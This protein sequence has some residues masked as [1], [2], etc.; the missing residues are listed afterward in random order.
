M[1]FS[2]AKDIS[3]S[4]AKAFCDSDSAVGEVLFLHK[5][6]PSRDVVYFG[7][8]SKDLWSIDSEDMWQEQVESMSLLE[9][10]DSVRACRVVSSAR[11]A[12]DSVRSY[13]FLRQDKRIVPGLSGI[14]HFHCECSDALKI[15][16]Q[17]LRSLIYIYY[18]IVFPK[19]VLSHSSDV[20]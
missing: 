20:G 2:Q 3:K 6:E 12:V 5:S 1:D 13:G 19:S 4:T 16:S 10:K 9:V 14:N 18:I 11:M 15:H 17:V 8:N 7:L